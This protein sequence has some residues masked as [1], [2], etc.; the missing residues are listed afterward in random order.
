MSGPRDQS[1]AP[2]TDS[3]GPRSAR[4]FRNQ[5]HSTATDVLI[6][7]R[8]GANA[9]GKSLSDPGSLV[10]LLQLREKR[11][12]LPQT[13]AAPVQI[14]VS[15]MLDGCGNNALTVTVGGALTVGTDNAGHP[16][17]GS[18]RVSFDVPHVLQAAGDVARFIWVAT[19]PR[20]LPPLDDAAAV[21]ENG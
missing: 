18:F 20:T 15:A 1:T 5:L 21:D 10:D 3:V 6:L 12:A 19:Q 7:P 9:V 2:A 13:Q 14:P 4:S 11:A 17:D 16:Q 8:E